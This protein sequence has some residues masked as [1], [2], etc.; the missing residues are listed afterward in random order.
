MDETTS[1]PPYLLRKSQIAAMQGTAKTHFLNPNAQRQNKSLGD[2]TGLTGVGIH[3]IEVQPGLETTEFHRHHH[4]DEALYILAGTATARIGDDMFSVE[5]GDF[6]GYRKGGR[7]HSL[8][9]TGTT[10]LLCLV[11][12]ERLPHDVS[13]YPDLGKRLYRSA[14]LPWS[15]MALDQ[16]E[17]LGGAVGKK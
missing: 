15:L 13:D 16:I 14:G 4:E 1:N 6:L 7:G 2:A 12:G 3:L 11:I 9:N 8:K 17:E 10:P 5:A